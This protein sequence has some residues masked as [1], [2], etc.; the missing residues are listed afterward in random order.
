MIV[1]QQSI[2]G[3]HLLMSAPGVRHVLGAPKSTKTLKDEIQGTIRLMDYGKTK[4][5]L[6]A[7]ADGTVFSIM[8][9]DRRQKT[10]TGVGVG[11]T[12]R[13]L[14]RGVKSLHCTAPGANRACTVGRELA[15]KRVTRFVLSGGRVRQITLGF[16][17]D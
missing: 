3:V 14:K 13:A 11:S 4:V 17:I 16:V 10:A 8:T 2:D 6:S 7:T 15:G 1:P 12:E 9:T 5:Y